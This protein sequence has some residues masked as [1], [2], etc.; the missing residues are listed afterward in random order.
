MPNDKYIVEA[1]DEAGKL[2]FRDAEDNPH[3]Q[4]P[5]WMLDCTEDQLAQY[6]FRETDAESVDMDTLRKW[7]W[8]TRSWTYRKRYW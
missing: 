3:P 2:L 7:L 5:T 4:P 8:G 1:R 6:Y